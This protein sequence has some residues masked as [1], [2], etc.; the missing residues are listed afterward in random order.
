MSAYFILVFLFIRF[1]SSAIPSSLVRYDFLYQQC[2]NNNFLPTPTN[3]P[4]GSF[5]KQTSS[6][7]CS[8]LDSNGVRD[9]MLVQTAGSIAQIQKQFSN[10]LSFEFWL[11]PSLDPTKDITLLSIESSYKYC[12]AS[13][14][15][16]LTHRAGGGGKYSVLV[17]SFS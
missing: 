6:A 16:S 10:T 17:F 1:A 12:Q 14:E 15:I 2:T 7:D 5:L 9:G 8:C 13:F 3:S 4:L 11:K